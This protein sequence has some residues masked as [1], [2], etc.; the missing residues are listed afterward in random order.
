MASGSTKGIADVVFCLD[1]SMS[2]EPCI[3]GVKANISSFVDGLQ[4]SPNYVGWDLR[5]DYIAHSA[6]ERTTGAIFKDKNWVF[7]HESVYYN[8][9]FSNPPPDVIDALYFPQAGAEKLFTTSVADFTSALSEVKPLGN[10]ASLVALDCCLD[11]PWRDATNCHRVVIFMTDQALEEGALV[12]LQTEKLDTLIEKIQ[13]LK[14]MLFIIA[15]ESEGYEMISEADKCEYQEVTGGGGLAGINYSEVLA[16]IGKSVSV[17][18]AT[19][20]G[21]PSAEVERG[22]FGQSKWATQSGGDLNFGDT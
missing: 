10:E 4:A 14:V 2:M 22:L 12:E 16:G 6:I 17:S 11:F 15:P 5:M 18:I 8:D 13:E 21:L 9:P 7:R 3:E 20:Q 19:L 1:A